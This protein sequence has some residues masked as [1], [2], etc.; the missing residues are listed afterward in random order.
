MEN[1]SITSNILIKNENNIP[2]KPIG[3]PPIE[4]IMTLQEQML[5]LHIKRKNFENELK[6]LTNSDNYTQKTV[7][8]MEKIEEEIDFISNY[9]NTLENQ[10]VVIMNEHNVKNIPKLL[11]E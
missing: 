4:N 8:D 11:F 6:L 1:T 2:Q 9:Y 3:R 7:D 5:K 10:L